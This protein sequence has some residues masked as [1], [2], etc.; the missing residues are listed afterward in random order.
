MTIVAE[1]PGGFAD[2]VL[3]AQS[4]FRSVMDAMR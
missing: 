4:T 3:S 2:R 1:L